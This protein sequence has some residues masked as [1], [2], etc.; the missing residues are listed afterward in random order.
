MKA[1]RDS[2]IRA[3]AQ[4]VGVERANEVVAGAMAKAGARAW[5]EPTAGKV[6][7]ELAAMGGPVAIAARRLRMAGGRLTSSQLER[8]AERDVTRA[9]VEL[10]TPSLGAEK[11]SAVVSDE[12]ARRGL[13]TLSTEAALA[14]LEALAQQGGPIGTVAR[15]AKARAHLALAVAAE[16]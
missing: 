13:T 4:V 8:G 6:L 11:A 2:V 10:L 12:K 14:V 16:R 7:D 3:L 5:D 1:S 15:F 9:L